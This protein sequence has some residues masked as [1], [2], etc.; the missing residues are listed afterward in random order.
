MT[1]AVQGH[2][3]LDAETLGMILESISDFAEQQLPQERLLELDKSHEFPEDTVRGMCA[4]LGV[5]LLF[6]PEEYG[7]MGAGAFD[8]Y[9]VCELLAGIDLAIATG[10]FATFLG[11]DPILFGGTE[12]QKALW[13]G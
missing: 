13:M 1:T 11:S 7:G 4:E 6:I 5:Q 2:A 9:R 3:G 8:V 12:E 10:V